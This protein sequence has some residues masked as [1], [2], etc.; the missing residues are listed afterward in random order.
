M[1]HHQRH[2]LRLL[3][4]LI[5]IVPESTRGIIDCILDIPALKVVIADVDDEVVFVRDLV[6]LDHCCKFL[7]R[8]NARTGGESSKCVRRW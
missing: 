3:H 2:L 7:S 1:E 8:F 5:D 6:A 4:E